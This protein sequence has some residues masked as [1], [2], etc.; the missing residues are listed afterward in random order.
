MFEMGCVD[1]RD[2]RL[3]T[4]SKTGRKYRLER[5]WYSDNSGGC[6][7]IERVYVDTTSELELAA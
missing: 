2:E 6:S 3:F 1:D 5:V 4:D 7:Q